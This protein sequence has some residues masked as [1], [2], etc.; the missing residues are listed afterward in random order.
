MSNVIKPKRGTTDPAPGVLAEGEIGINTSAA[1]AFVGVAGGGNKKLNA[2]NSE[3]TDA[4]NSTGEVTANVNRHIW[5]SDADDEKK[6][7]YNGNFKYNP[8]TNTISSNVSGTS[9]NVTGTVGIANGGTGNTTRDLALTALFAGGGG[10]TDANIVASGTYVLNTDTASNL[11]P[12]HGYY[13]LTVFRY[14]TS[15]LACGQIAI[16][17][18]NG[19]L[20]SRDYVT[21][22]WRDWVCCSSKKIDTIAI[23][24]GADLN[25]YRDKGFYASHLVGNSISNLPSDLGSGAFEL[26]VTGI[27]SDGVCCTQ[28]LKSFFSNKLWVRTQK[29]WHEPWD[30]TNWEQIPV[31]SEV[32]TTD[33]DGIEL[34][35]NLNSH[36][37][38]GGYIDFHFNGSSKDYTSRL[39]E[40][41]EGALQTTG[42]FITS[43]YFQ[44]FG[45][46]WVSGRGLFVNSDVY[47][48]SLPAAGTSGRVFFKKV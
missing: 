32:V 44:S 17:L 38:Y 19:N 30:W 12:E 45:G 39:M 25:D 1:T 34:G 35:Q 28:W 24:N 33:T 43:G 8:S 5:F 37:N 46:V 2:G 41:S 18:G 7:A 22:N 42:S 47:G 29:N 27:G 11:P 36:S 4:V 6:R 3:T 14:D 9:S 20:Y 40:T 15:D 26:V 13:L 21:G 23:P 10:E 31:R 16:N 48:T